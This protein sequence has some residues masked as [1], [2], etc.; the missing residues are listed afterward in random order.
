MRY[1]NQVIFFLSNVEKLPLFL[2][3]VIFRIFG[4]NST[5]YTNIFFLFFFFH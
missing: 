2:Y 3:D 5:D 4:K 1:K